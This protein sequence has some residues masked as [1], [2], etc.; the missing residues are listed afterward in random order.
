[1]Y[2]RNG[3]SDQHETLLEMV[4]DLSMARQVGQGPTGRHA[5]LP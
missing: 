2:D 3:K 4:R 5:A 1:M